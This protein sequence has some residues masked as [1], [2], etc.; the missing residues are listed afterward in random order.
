MVY[1]NVCILLPLPLPLSLLNAFF[2]FRFI[3]IF[4]S[5][6]ILFVSLSPSLTVPVPLGFCGS[7]GFQQKS[8]IYVMAKH[9]RPQTGDCCSNIEQFVAIFFHSSL[10]R[11]FIAVL[12]FVQSTEVEKRRRGKCK[13]SQSE[14]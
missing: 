4:I 11:F 3:F 12:H 7:C 8:I 2:R 9:W 10:L 14:Y 5:N 6:F 1:G 13:R